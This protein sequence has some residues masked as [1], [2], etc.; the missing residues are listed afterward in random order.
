MYHGECQGEPV[1]IESSILVFELDFEKSLQFPWETPILRTITPPWDLLCPHTCVQSIPSA[2][3]GFLCID[4]SEICIHH[5]NPQL[6]LTPLENTE[7]LSMQ[8]F[9]RYIRLVMTL[10]LS[11]LPCAAVYCHVVGCVLRIVE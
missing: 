11:N 8:L 4:T 3:S 9:I 5:S 1:L 2:S 10:M 6:V 7:L